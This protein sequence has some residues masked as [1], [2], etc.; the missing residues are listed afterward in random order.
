MQPQPFARF[1]FQQKTTTATNKTSVQNSYEIKFAVG[2]TYQ[3]AC[4]TDWSI[5]RRRKKGGKEIIRRTKK[6]KE[7]R[8]TTKTIT[9]IMTI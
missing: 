6:E 1:C 9:L 7:R 2:Y 5:I 8:T 4:A 3:S